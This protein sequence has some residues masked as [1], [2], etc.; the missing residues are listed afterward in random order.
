MAQKRKAQDAFGQSNGQL[1]AFAAARLAKQAKAAAPASSLASHAQQRREEI[2]QQLNA[3][4]LASVP[5]DGHHDLASADSEPEEAEVTISVTTKPA[6]TLSPSTT[7]TSGGKI[8]E[9]IDGSIEATLRN[10]HSIVCV[11]EYD[12]EV[13]KGLVTVYGATLHPDSGTQRIYAPSTH[14]LPRIIARRN[15]TKLRVSHVKSTIAKLAKLSPLFRNIWTKNDQLNQSFRL[16]RSAA[17]DELQRSLTTLEIDKSTETAI[18]RLTNDAQSTARLVRIMAIG[19][20]SSGKST[21][22]RILCNA[23][24]TKQSARKVLYLDLDPGQPEFG[25]PGQVSLV[26]VSAP[27]WGPSFTHTASAEQTHYKF[28]R[29][30]TLAA[31]SF[32]D[33]AEHYVACA[34]ELIRHAD[35]RQTIIVNACGWVSGLGASVTRELADVLSISHIAL[36]EPLDTSLV[37]SLHG[38]CPDASFLSLT[39]QSVRPSSRTPAELR[40]MQTMAYFHARPDH[41]AEHTR[42]S[43]KVISTWRPWIVQYDGPDAPL[44]AIVSCGQQPHPDFLAEVLDGSL[45]ALVQVETSLNGDT[46]SWTQTNARETAEGVAIQRTM[47]G[48]PYLPPRPSGTSLTLDPHNSSCLGLTLVRGIDA[49]QRTLHLLT[50]LADHTMA[51]LLDSKQ[52]VLVGGSFDPPEWALL[53]DVYA[54]EGNA[55]GDA[56]LQDRPWVS[57]RERVGIEGA[58]WRLRHPP[59]AGDVR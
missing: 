9:L 33:D 8:D 52:L 51:S 11:G 28:L 32:K 42:W 49:S 41:P 45:V 4:A 46:L 24:S 55:K 40:S 48:L 18:S 39:R 59:M 50:P 20:K 2:E 54:G 6:V 34:K 38:A 30:H 56:S 53:E 36:L 21:F 16:L 12:L 13:Q 44:R 5:Y 27:M 58:V 57:R 3:T 29:S 10:N 15:G 1:S 43:S 47:G 23:L 7:F 37:E 19:A 25:P 22:N 17:G 26:E 31:T 35:R 14:A